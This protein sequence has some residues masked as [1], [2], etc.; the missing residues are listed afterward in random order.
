MYVGQL[1]E[2]LWHCKACRKYEKIFLIGHSMGGAIAA[3]F[4][5]L[6]PQHIAGLVLVAPAGLPVPMPITAHIA[7]L[8]LVGELIMGGPI[9]MSELKALA[10]RGYSDLKVL[11]R[12]QNDED[13]EDS[14]M[15]P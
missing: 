7:K 15:S 11:L 5:E 13:V 8:P 9:G 2:L 3:A 12:G 10:A 14:Q 1:A 4:A 6:Y